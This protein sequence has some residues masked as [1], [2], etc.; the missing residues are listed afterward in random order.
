MF[1]GRADEALDEDA[2]IIDLGHWA[3]LSESSARLARR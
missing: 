3:P 1:P 2:N